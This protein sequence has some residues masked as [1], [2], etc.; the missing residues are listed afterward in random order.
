MELLNKDVRE[1]FLLDI[2]GE[3]LGRM[4]LTIEIVPAALEVFVP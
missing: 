2:D 4:P 1:S 3:P